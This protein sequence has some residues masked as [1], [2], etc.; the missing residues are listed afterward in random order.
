[1]LKIIPFDKISLL[2][3]AVLLIS[4]DSVFLDEER[5][6][7][8]V[9]NF[10]SL[11]EEF[12]QK[13]GLF[14]VKE[15]DWD[16]VYAVYRPQSSQIQSNQELYDLLTE[17]LAGLND[18]HVALLPTNGSG[19]PFYQSGELGKLD[20]MM[21]FSLEI[22][23][24]HY[25]TD[26]KFADPFFT[27][28]YLDHNI[29]YIHIEGF[30]DLPKFLEGPMDE[31][32]SALENTTGLIIDVRGGYGGEDLAGQYIASRFADEQK[33]Y[34]KT[35]VKSGPGPDDLT[36]FETWEIKPEGSFQYQKPIVVLTHRFTISARETFCLAMKTLPQVTIVGDTTAGAFSNQINRE[37]PNGW[38]Y[39]LSI[40]EWLDADFQSH[41]GLGIVPDVLVEN[42][43]SDL[44]LGK[45]EAVET[46]ISL[47]R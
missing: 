18:S 30:S 20:S 6:N 36:S 1:M 28:G 41:E 23:K 44:L 3:I 16:S 37:L 14:R 33:V 9:S 10:E 11:W 29:G 21:D 47:L 32:L 34:M 46:A 45:D 40:G 12:D 17:M 26:A 27:Y 19:L 35:R 13:Y 25:L 24:T 42:K 43:K 2:L 38:G 31:V 4:C 22:I 39:S 7:H 5:P 15:I 8:P